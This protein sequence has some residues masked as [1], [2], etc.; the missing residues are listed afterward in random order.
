[1]TT[2]GVNAPTVLDRTSVLVGG[3]Q[4]FVRYVSPGQV[5]VQ[6]PS[7]VLTGQQQ[8]VVSTPVTASA[9]FNITVNA[10]QPG[11]LAPP[12]FGIG[13]KQYVVAQ[14][15]DGAYVLPANAIPGVPSRPAK[16]GETIVIYGIG[17]GPV[18]GVAAGQVAPAASDLVTRPQIFFGPSSA[19]LSYAGLAGGFVGLYQFNVVVPNVAANDLVPLTFTLSGA[20]G[21]QT[22]FTAVGN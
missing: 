22:L 17:F 12:S 6:V 7:N 16:P 21:A 8:I 18:S 19:T 15:A 14:F 9:A 20:S 5:N 10:T 4:A 2:A 13:G 11:M 1:M 3:Q